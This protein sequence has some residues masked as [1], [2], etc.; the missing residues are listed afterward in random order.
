VPLAE[1]LYAQMVHAGQASDLEYVFI[2]GKQVVADRKVLA[3]DT[4]AI[5]RKALEYR[6]RISERRP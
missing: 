2:N 4:Q 3:V 5:Y 1:N 6:E